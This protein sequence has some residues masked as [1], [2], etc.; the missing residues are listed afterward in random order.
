V[1]RADDPDRSGLLLLLQTAKEKSLR[2]EN[3][4]A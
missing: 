3:S 2:M 4:R 1:G